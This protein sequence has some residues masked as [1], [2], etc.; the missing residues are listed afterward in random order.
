VNP[1]AD[2]TTGQ[3]GIVVSI[4]NRGGLVGGLFADGRVQ[5]ER[6]QAPVI[7]ANAVDI[8]GIRPWVLRLKGGHAERVEV[9]LGIKDEENERYEVLS[10]IV[11]G[12]TL[13]IGAAQGITAG[14]PV[15]VSAPDDQTAPRR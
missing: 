2:A 11:A 9:E 1:S 8:R 13:L 15:R 14:T 10:G 6:R 3:V 12:D 4:P 5:A 7:A